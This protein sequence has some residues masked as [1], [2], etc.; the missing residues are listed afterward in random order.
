M[1]QSNETLNDFIFGNCTNANANENE[2]LEPQTSGLVDS[3]E[4]FAVTDNSAVHDKVV[5][6][7]IAVKIRSTMLLQLSKIESLARF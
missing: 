3:S 4:N 7:K 6:R 1:S 2:T 5:E